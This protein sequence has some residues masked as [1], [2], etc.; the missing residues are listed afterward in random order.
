MLIEGEEDERAQSQDESRTRPPE[1]LKARED[2]APLVRSELREAPVT[3]RERRPDPFEQAE[4]HGKQQLKRHRKPHEVALHL[5]EDGVVDWL[6]EAVTARANRS[7]R[8]P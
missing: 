1:A 2:G 3:S 4:P 6:I 5:D 7:D 8:G